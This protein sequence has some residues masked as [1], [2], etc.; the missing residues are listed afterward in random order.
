M[1]YNWTNWNHGAGCFC[2]F[3]L[4]SFKSTPAVKSEKGAVDVKKTEP[5]VGYVLEHM[6]IY[7]SALVPQSSEDDGGLLHA[8]PPSLESA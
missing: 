5:D 6:S 2:L 3:E 4:F 1:Q 7:S 8:T